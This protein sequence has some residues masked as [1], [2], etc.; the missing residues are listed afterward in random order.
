MVHCKGRGALFAT[1]V[2]M[3]SGII[4]AKNWTVYLPRHQRLNPRRFLRWTKTCHFFSSS[5]PF[6]PSL[7][8]LFF[9]LDRHCVCALV[10]LCPGRK[11]FFM[12]SPVSRGGVTMW[13]NVRV[14]WTHHVW[15]QRRISELNALKV[16]L[17][18]PPERWGIDRFRNSEEKS[19]QLRCC[20]IF[21]SRDID[22]SSDGQSRCPDKSYARMISDEARAHW[23]THRSINISTT[24]HPTKKCFG[25]F[26]C[27]IS[28]SSTSERF[29]TFLNISNVGFSIANMKEKFQTHIHYSE[30]P[31]RKPPNMYREL[32]HKRL[33]WI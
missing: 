2:E 8:S 7:R 6:R 32:E 24:L 3:M 18:I 31:G 28:W 9:P 13:L 21:S 11:V 29:K 22:R 16:F 10:R 5:P 27:G 25:T 19:L 17:S 30:S 15:S 4:V 33:T 23:L 20:P 26:R 12:D 14:V 1:N